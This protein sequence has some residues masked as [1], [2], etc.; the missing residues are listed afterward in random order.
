MGN[1]TLHADMEK[2]R[3]FLADN[4]IT[5]YSI[6][7]VGLPCGEWHIEVRDDNDALIWERYA[8]SMHAAIH[9]LAERIEYVKPSE[10]KWQLKEND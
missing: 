6:W 7:Y 8:L 9:A 3:A 1:D 10:G 5:G 4:P 2:I